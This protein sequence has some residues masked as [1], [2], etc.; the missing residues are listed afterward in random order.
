[1]RYFVIITGKFITFR[2]RTVCNILEG[3]TSMSKTSEFI[4]LILMIRRSDIEE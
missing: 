4:N 3:N 1:M 2:L